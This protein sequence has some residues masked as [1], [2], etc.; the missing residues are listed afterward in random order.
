M[1]VRISSRRHLRRSNW[2]RIFIA[3]SKMERPYTYIKSWE[4]LAI[5]YKECQL[6]TKFDT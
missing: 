4:N 2:L 1:F 6:H 3:I 5:G